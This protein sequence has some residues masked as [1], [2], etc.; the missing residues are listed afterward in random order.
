MLWHVEE[1]LRVFEQ[2]FGHE[3]DEV[4]VDWKKLS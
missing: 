4:V 1:K 2:P 3:R